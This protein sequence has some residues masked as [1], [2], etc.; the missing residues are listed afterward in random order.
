MQEEEEKNSSIREE[1]SGLQIY[2]VNIRYLGQKLTYDL[3][4]V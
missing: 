2:T 1:R 3:N 4:C